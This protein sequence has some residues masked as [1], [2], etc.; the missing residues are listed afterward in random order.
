KQRTQI[1]ISAWKLT[2]PVPALDEL[3]VCVQLQRKITTPWTAFMYSHE[4]QPAET[5]EL[6]LTGKHNSLHV[7]HSGRQWTAEVSLPINEWCT[8]CFT[9]SSFPQQVNLYI[10]GSQ[11]ESLVSV[12]PSDYHSCCQ[13]K[14][15][16]TL[17]LG[18]SH[19]FSEGVM[20]P[21]TGTNFQG[22]IT[23]FRVW[24]EVLTQ[25][26][27]N[28]CLGGNVVSWDAADWDYMGC[29]PVRNSHEHC[30]EVLFLD[31]KWY[32]MCLNSGSLS[33]TSSSL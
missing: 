9:V 22:S 26:Q 23:L 6:G 13:L 24:G 2:R 20:I 17:T 14:P 11:V 5:I 18:A 19:Y 3:S 7:W 32:E 15:G 10:N 31:L 30:G 16:G 27:L 25:R 33:E 1:W 29:P 12:G 21:E 4:T 8:I 28:G